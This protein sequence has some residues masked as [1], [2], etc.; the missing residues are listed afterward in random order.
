MSRSS[1]HLGELSKGYD[2]LALTGGTLLALEQCHHLIE[3]DSAVARVRWNALIVR[4]KY[5][6]AALMI[7]AE[8]SLT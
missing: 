4:L 7:T 2:H 3:P 6:A 8:W 1:E 5:S